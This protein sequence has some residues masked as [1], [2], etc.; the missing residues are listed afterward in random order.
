M[1][2]NN[3]DLGQIE[4]VINKLGGMLGLADFLSNRT[5][6]VPNFKVWKSI[7][8]GLKINKINNID[9][10]LDEVTDISLDSDK[11]AVA[12]LKLEPCKVS[13]SRTVN[14]ARVSFSDLGITAAKVTY[15]EMLKRA[16]E[17]GLKPCSREI[18]LQSMI[19]GTEVFEPT[20]KGGPTFYVFGMHP[21]DHKFH[22][23][24]GIVQIIS[25]ARNG[26]SLW[27]PDYSSDR[28]AY[29]T[30]ET[31]LLRTYIFEI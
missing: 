7:K 19:Q 27:M 20:P 26:K 5:K 11:D 10:L 14:L 2:Y 22:S 12:L 6:I 28:A 21:I 13:K 17:L 18:I 3:V 8:V 4:A 31:Q 9:K 24:I 30:L 29:N 23:G 15:P 1:K 25:S 16:I